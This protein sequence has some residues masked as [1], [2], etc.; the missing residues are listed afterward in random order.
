MSR[1]RSAAHKGLEFIIV[2]VA[3]GL[4]CGSG[5]PFNGG[6]AAPQQEPWQS[7]LLRLAIAGVWRIPLAIA[8]GAI[9]GF[10]FGFVGGWLSY[11][12][13]QS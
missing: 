9:V 1:L 4:I 6:D 7:H 10:I 3:F 2:G 13:T 11:R 8:V 12:S 5:V